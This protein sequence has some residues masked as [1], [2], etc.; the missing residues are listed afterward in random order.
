[1]GRY[2]RWQAAIA[3]LGLVLLAAL[4][5]YSAYS[6]TTTTVPAQGGVYVEGLAG[7]PQYINPLLSHYNSVDQDLC[8]LIFQGLT[9]FDEQGNVV[10]ALAERWDISPDGLVYTFTLRQDVRWHDGIPFTADDVLYS[11][12]VVQDADFQ[13]LPDIRELWRR[14]QVEKLD[15][16]TVRFTLAEPF[17]PF[18]D[19]TTMGLLPAHLWKEIP[20]RLMPRAQLNTR[21][22]GTGP[23]RLTEVDA[24]HAVLEP[25][26]Y[27][28][29]KPPYLE[30]VEFRFYP[31][32]QSIYAAFERGE[33]DAISRILP[34]DLGWA[35]AIEEM[36]ILSAPL[37]GFVAILLNLNNPNTPQLQE[38]EVRQALLYALDRQALI[39][40]A[41]G[42][43]GVLAHSPIVP[44]TWAYH[45][46]VRHYGYEPETARAL[47]EEAGWRD[48]DGDGVR[49]KGE[50][51][52][53][54]IL[55]GDD[56][57]VRVRM[58]EMIAADW[59]EVGVR[60]VPQPV[61]FAG[62]VS[63]FLYPRHF[64]AALV[65]WELSGDPDPYPLWHSTQVEGG[66]NYAG[67]AHRRADE[68]MEEARMTGD[69]ARRMALYR[70]F[71]DIFAE[72]LPA[73]PLFHPVY[74]YGVR[75][76]VQGVT[77]GRLNEPSDRFRTIADWY[78][79]TR[80]LT[81][82]E[83]V[84]RDIPGSAGKGP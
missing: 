50:Q 15:Q 27:A 39:D 25:N 45:Q 54:F 58:L 77:I 57:A 34:G 73:L 16:H 1:M 26:P 33:V 48:G 64:D 80:R 49:E 61:S 76:K 63:D 12:G 7:N 44:R 65:S 62:L 8:A 23:F 4:L 17:T 55:L 42:G 13:G 78:I 70:E 22:V 28:R 67:W 43:E 59:A 38:K 3:F 51:R 72:E 10:P 30:A 32:Y 56:D 14:V 74:S 75:E 71:Q 35:A 41:T 66:Q 68:I 83:A 2:I 31:D 5:A 69:Q 9:A 84:E 11:I 60:A 47:L 18:L 19:Y 21:P 52:L 37:A 79:V 24:L 82:R 81:V 46:E 53:E 29:G 20:P 36:N 6:V 40:Q